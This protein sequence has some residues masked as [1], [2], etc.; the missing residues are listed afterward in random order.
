[1]R[2]QQN[3]KACYTYVFAFLD[4]HCYT[5]P[6]GATGWG[7]NNRGRL[8]NCSSSITIQSWCDD[9]DLFI[10]HRRRQAGIQSHTLTNSTTSPV[11]KRP[12]FCRPTGQEKKRERCSQKKKKNQRCR[13][14]VS[15]TAMET[16]PWWG[17]TRLR[18]SV[19]THTHTHTHIH[20]CRLTQTHK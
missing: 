2:L 17:S 4:W 1:M 14:K 3:L 12:R 16:E 8:R 20:V 7:K 11:T 9:S 5:A 10:Y 18:A 19:E 15:A 6:R 13:R